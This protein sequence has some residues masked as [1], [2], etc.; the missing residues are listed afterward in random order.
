VSIVLISQAPSVEIANRL[1]SND[2]HISVFLP[3]APKPD[4]GLLLL[5]ARSKI[6]EIEMSAEDAATLDHVLRR[7]AA[8]FGPAEEDRSPG[9]DG[10]CRAGGECGECSHAAAGEGGVRL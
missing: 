10:E 4:H 1:P 7:G 3:C 6:L 5:R 8:R 2:E 9:G